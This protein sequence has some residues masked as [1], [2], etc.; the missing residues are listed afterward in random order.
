LLQS[1]ADYMHAIRTVVTMKVIHPAE[2]GRRD[3]LK[4]READRVQEFLEKSR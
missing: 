1:G 2:V 4:Y 3:K